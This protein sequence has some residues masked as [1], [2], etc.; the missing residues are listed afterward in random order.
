LRASTIV[1]LLQGRSFGRYV[2]IVGV[3]FMGTY[4]LILNIALTIW[5]YAARHP[6]EGLARSASV[7]LAD[8]F[9]SGKLLTNVHMSYT[10]GFIAGVYCWVILY[11]GR[12]YF[13]RGPATDKPLR[14]SGKMTG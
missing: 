13:S 11:I 10:L 2:Y 4:L 7:V 6:G 5:F 8:M 12:R 3:L 1:S 9:S 14:R